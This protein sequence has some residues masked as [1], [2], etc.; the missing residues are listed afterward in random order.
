MKRLIVTALALLSL[1]ACVK[2]EPGLVKV[3][4]G[5]IQGTVTDEMA[6][7]KGVPF[8][9]PPVGDLRW[10]APQP[11]IAWEGVRPATEFGK[12]PVQGARNTDAFGE[13]CLYLNIWSPAK[14]PKDKLPVMVWIY[15]GGFGAGNSAQFDG[16]PLARKGVIL[17]TVNY[18]IGYL[19]FLAHPD[20]S[21][22]NPEGVSGN[23]GL[24]D[25]IAALK[26]V[27][28]N[29]GAFGGDPGN[30]TIFGESA[31]GISVSM[32][33]ASP[34][35]KGLFRSAI[36]QSGG[37]FGPYRTTSYPGENM[38]LLS[39]AEQEGVAFAQSMGA[40]SIA[41][42]RAMDPFKFVGG[43]MTGGAW[44]IVDGYVIP[45]DQY[46]MYESGN[47]NDVNILVG[48]NSDE[49][50]S[51]SREKDP[52][53]YRASI[54]ERFGPYTDA[55]M[56]AYPVTATTVP[57]SGRD[58][59]RDAAFGWHTWV[60]C[61]L[62]AEKG[63]SNVYLYYFDQH[64]DY[65][66]G[67]PQYGQ[68]SPHGQDVN[69]VFQVPDESLPTNKALSNIIGDYWTN[70]AKY[71]NPNGEGLPQWPEF[72]L[73]DSK[74]MYLTGDQPFAGPV[75]DEK[76]LWVMDSYFAWRRSPEGAAWA[77]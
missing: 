57:K 33:C 12:G 10:K 29:I 1:C 75:P 28:N 27:Q 48:Y 50:A 41:D 31:G 54:E 37:S 26:W 22:E 36:S 2:N 39:V 13:D 61:R 58:L 56:E 23:Y 74:A 4:G 49:G 73:E 64:K 6:I 77:K 35:A 55:L 66:E 32:L 45:D 3:E 16:A 25:Q 59:M 52:A 44:P 53:K 19:G 69:F 63:D 71:G 46:K 24:L 60:W 8:A 43:P 15:G 42:L 65:P 11:V 62:Q 76:S 21:K 30:V 70:F 7:Y 38:K 14:S 18:R 20:L 9:A 34:L 72:T 67:S 51:F 68:G 47:F 17:V 5:L 40:S